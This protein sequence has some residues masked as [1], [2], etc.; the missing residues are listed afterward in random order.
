[1]DISSPE[2]DKATVLRPACAPA[3]ASEGVDG[4]SAP[5][6][7]RKEALI[8][9]DSLINLKVVQFL[10]LYASGETI[11]TDLCTILLIAHPSPYRHTATLCR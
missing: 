10:F 8:V 5:A 9:D 3:A 2:P 7:G 6:A 11:A 1:V 4:A